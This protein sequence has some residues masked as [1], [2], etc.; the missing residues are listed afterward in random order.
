[1]SGLHKVNVVVPQLLQPHYTCDTS[2]EHIEEFLDNLQNHAEGGL[3]L[4]PDFQRNLVWSRSQSSKY[5]GWI[6]RGGESGRELLW[7]CPGWGGNYKGTME[8]VDGKQR[9]NAVRLWVANEIPA[10]C[11]DGSSWY[12]RDFMKIL[13]TQYSLKMRIGNFKKRSQV[14]Q[15]YL[16]FNSG[17]MAHTKEELGKVREL[18]EKELNKEFN[19]EP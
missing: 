9:L 15:W 17:G 10:D 5:V 18:L 11:G 4:D 8:I 7:N 2:I 6:L 19:R 1:M 13:G 14:L 12:R 16:D 3:D